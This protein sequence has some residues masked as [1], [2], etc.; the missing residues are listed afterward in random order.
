MDDKLTNILP[1]PKGEYAVNTTW[2]AADKL[3]VTVTLFGSLS[4]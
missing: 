3:R 2:F 1:F 4:Q